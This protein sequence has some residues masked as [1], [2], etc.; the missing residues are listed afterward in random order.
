M[1]SIGKGGQGA[2]ASVG[3]RIMCGLAAFFATV[4]LVSE[5]VVMVSYAVPTMAVM[6]Y[7]YGRIDLNQ[8][9]L[10]SEF[11]V[12]DAVLLTMLWVA[13][14]LVMCGLAVLVQWQIMKRAWRL[15]WRLVMAS[16][17]RGEAAGGRKGD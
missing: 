1:K 5:T 6:L 8:T 2:G 13:P 17:G 3:R 7:S 14:V 11:A 16:A 9:V 10:I 4:L 15:I 12:K